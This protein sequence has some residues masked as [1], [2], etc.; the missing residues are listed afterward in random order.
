M[1]HRCTQKSFSSGFESKSFAN[2]WNKDIRKYWSKK[3]CLNLTV[4]Q[5][6]EA[7]DGQNNIFGFTVK[8]FDLASFSKV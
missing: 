6:S 8:D 4:H 5:Q 2:C 7:V 3:K 1:A